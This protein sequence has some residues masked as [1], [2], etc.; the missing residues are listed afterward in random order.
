MAL[1]KL[2][3]LTSSVDVDGT[4][5]HVRGLTRGENARVSHLIEAGKVEEAEC[6]VIAAATDTPIA[7]ANDWYDNTPNKYVEAVLAEVGR[8]TRLSEGASKSG[9]PGV[10]AGRG[11]R[12]G[13][14]AGGETEQDGG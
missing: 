11:D 7:D 14:P 1:P 5:V 9:E 6:F 13:F 10:H 12:L 3:H 2:G 4:S 8:L